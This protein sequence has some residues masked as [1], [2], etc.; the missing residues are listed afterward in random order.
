MGSPS[1]PPWGLTLIGALV[2]SLPAATRE[3]TQ[4]DGLKSQDDE[5]ML[6][7]TVHSQSYATFFFVI[8]PF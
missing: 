3:L 2:T 4:Q 1:L 5:K 7:E 6:D 8:L